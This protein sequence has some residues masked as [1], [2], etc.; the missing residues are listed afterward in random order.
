MAAAPLDSSSTPPGAAAAESD[1]TRFHG[2]PMEDTDPQSTRK[3]PRL[4][5]GSRVCESWSTD[6]MSGRTAAATAPVTAA[7]GAADQEASA[8]AASR[9]ASRVTI[10][11]KSPTTGSRE[12]ESGPVDDPATSSS[13]STTLPDQSSSAGGAPPTQSQSADTSN[14]AAGQASNNAISLSSSPVQSPE[15]EV[16]DVED[17][18]QDTNTTSTWKPLGEAMRD[19]VTPEVVQLQDQLSLTDTFPK[20][21]EH[22]GLRENLDEVC[23]IIEKGEGRKTHHGE[24]GRAVLKLRRSTGNPHD[25]TVFLAVK[26]WLDDAVNNLDQLTY[27]TY[28]DDRDFWEEF[29]VM[30]EFLL[31]RV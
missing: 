12:L 5:S 6:E 10:N 8:A 18:D 15:I 11:V 22:L 13:S 27:D 3:R 9:P 1:Q 25:V 24:A 30:V 31:R 19:R 29:P 28:T 2:D 26:N 4:D 21:H 7:D 20:L 17:V 14:T 16:A 23:A